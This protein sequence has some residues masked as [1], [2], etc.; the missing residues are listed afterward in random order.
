MPETTIFLCRDDAG[1]VREA[2]AED[3]MGGVMPLPITGFRMDQDSQGGGE[4]ELRFHPIRVRFE[5]Y[6]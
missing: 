5:D 1:R 4:V 3:G 6:V 2:R